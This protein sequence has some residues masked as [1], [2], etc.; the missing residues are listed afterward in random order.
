MDSGVL[1]PG[2]YLKVFWS[3]VTFISVEMMNDV[4]GAKAP[5]FL[6]FRNNAM[7]VATVKLTV[8]ARA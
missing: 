6:P 4:F 5:P 8:S 3:I 1:G 2:D 7:L